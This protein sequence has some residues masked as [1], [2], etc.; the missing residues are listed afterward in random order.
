MNT[1]LSRSVRRLCGFPRGGSGATVV[2]SM[3]ASPTAAHC[4]ASSARASA[5][6]GSNS[7]AGLTAGLSAILRMLLSNRAG[8]IAITTAFVMPVVIG[9]F[10][11][12]AEVGYWYFTQRKLQNAADVA[13][14][15]GAAQLRAGQT[16]SAIS[17]AAEAAAVETGYKA[18]IGTISTNWPAA[19]GT[20]AG[21][22]KTVESTI[23]ENVPRLFTSLFLGGSVPIQ[24]RAVARLDR[25][26][27]T[28]ILALHPS[29]AGAVTFIGSANASLTSCNVHANSTADDAVLVTGSG[30]VTTPCVSSVGQVSATAGLTMSE[31]AAPLEYIDPITDPFASVPEPSTAGPCEPVNVFAGPPS[32]SYVISPG[33]YCGGLSLKRRVDMN[34]GVYVVD[35]GTFEITSTATVRGTGITVFLTNGATLSFAGTA[36]IR[37]TAPTSGTYAGLLIFGDREDP[38]ATHIVNGDS[39]SYLDGAV[40]I[41]SGHVEFAGSNSTSGGCTQVVASTIEITGSTGLGGDCTGA[42]FNNIQSEQIVALVE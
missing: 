8:N 37:L 22:P 34:P 35:G 21:D 23:Q 18:S 7:K 4:H 28:C 10:G 31:C 24:A 11:L 33:R 19:T 2:P 40:Y 15:S 25:V 6:S 3:A 30:A 17:S 29:A 36:D 38:Y 16:Y 39:A 27:P 32:A 20:F 5:S 13:A 14:Y 9:G 1:I 42:G 41:P 26:A 12:G